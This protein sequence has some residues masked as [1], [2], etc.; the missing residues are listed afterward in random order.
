MNTKLLRHLTDLRQQACHPQIVRRDEWLGRA[1]LG[2]RA[3]MTRLVLRAFGEYDAALR[4]ELQA[5]ALLAAVSAEAASVGAPC[6]LFGVTMDDVQLQQGREECCSSA[7]RAARRCLCRGRRRRCM[8]IPCRISLINRAQIWLL[9][10]LF[11]SGFGFV[12][13][14]CSVCTAGAVARHL[15]DSQ[16][17]LFL[18]AHWRLSLCPWLLSQGE[19]QKEQ[20]R[21]SCACCKVAL[22]AH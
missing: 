21:R 18:L 17:R 9:P 19:I 14:A 12:A 10:A 13:S 8:Q 3:I 4:A 7:A 6:P 11:G 20:D 16:E 1:R 15:K 5:R 2:M 22:H